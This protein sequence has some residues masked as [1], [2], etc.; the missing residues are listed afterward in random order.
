[1]SVEKISPRRRWLH[2]DLETLIWF[3]G[4]EICW[5]RDRLPTPVFLGFPCGS[6]GK[7]ICL[8]C[9][10]PGFDPSVRKIPLEK[11]KVTHFSILAWSCN[12]HFSFIWVRKGVVVWGFPSRKNNL[13]VGVAEVPQSSRSGQ[14]RVDEE[15]DRRTRSGPGGTGRHRW[16]VG[17]VSH[18]RLW[19]GLWCNSV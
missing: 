13:W 3:L 6:A 5:R 11:G 9:R 8:Q 17:T 7:E 12:F 1:M 4:R 16:E 14:S 18:A 10:R 19:A 2:G 15:R